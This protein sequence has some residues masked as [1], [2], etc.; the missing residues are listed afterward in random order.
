MKEK[1]NKGTKPKEANTK[2]AQIPTL[3]I[4]ITL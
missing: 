4:C 1:I 3:Y 2:E